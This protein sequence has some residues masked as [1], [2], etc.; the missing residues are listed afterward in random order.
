MAMRGIILAGGTGTRLHPVTLATS[1]QL[2]PVYD[3]PLIYYPLTTLMLAGIRDILVITTPG[4]QEKFRTLLGDGSQWGMRL[5]YATQARP[6]GIA[7]ALLIAAAFIAGGPCA[8]ILGDNLFF[9]HGLSQ[10]VSD[11]A[12]HVSG[13]TIIAC[14]V[15]DPERYGVVTFDADGRPVAIEEKPR[16]PRSHW[17][18]TGLYFYDAG[19]VD[20]ARSIRPSARGELEITHVNEAYLRRGA[21]NVV[22]I[23]RGYA[24]FDTGTHDSLIDAANFVRTIETRQGLK[25]ACPEEIALARG[26]IGHEALER[27]IAE[28][29][30]KTNYGAYL[31]RLLA[32][33]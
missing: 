12:S 26:Y 17:A 10:I 27:L 7:Q 24:W 23:G 31:R 21:L 9:G 13:A 4:D 11:A 6:E 32:E 28:R 8:L 33:S 30:D 5:G 14:R 2:L 20:I 25:I 16:H 22:K 18:V 29:Y 19:V 3:K 1:K 15:E